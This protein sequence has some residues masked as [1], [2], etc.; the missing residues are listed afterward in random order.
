MINQ[1][2]PLRIKIFSILHIVFGTWGLIVTFS[3]LSKL[4]AI[5]RI[6]RD[7]GLTSD[8]VI[9]T[10][11]FSSR[12]LQ[13]V[14]SFLYPAMFLILLILGIGLLMK[15]PWA[16]LGAIIY[17]FVAI[18]FS[19]WIA[20]AVAKGFSEISSSNQLNQ[21]NKTIISGFTNEVTI[22]ALFSLGY[23]ALAILSLN[24][25]NVKATQD[26]RDENKL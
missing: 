12:T 22:S 15:K 25:P 16:R 6:L 1:P 11:N 21:V 14:M 19:I 4:N 7:L 18:A 3:W 2:I 23:Q 20:I 5:D 10:I 8:V 13:P 24:R 26:K 17:G 9:K